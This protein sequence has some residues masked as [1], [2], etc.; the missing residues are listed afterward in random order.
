MSIDPEAPD[1]SLARR[2]YRQMLRLRRFEAE[3]G[4]AAGWRGLESVPAG[5]IEALAPGD[6]VVES[7]PGAVA[8]LRG[9]DPAAWLASG[10]AQPSRPGPAAPDAE[11]TGSA[12]LD[13]ALARRVLAAGSVVVQFL[14]AGAGMP[15][16][17]GVV[18]QGPAPRQRGAGVSTVLPVDALDAVAV[19]QAARQALAL[20]R[21]GEG[22]VLLA[23]AT[24]DSAG[25]PAPGPAA[26]RDP[27]SDPIDRLLAWARDHLL[28]S[29]CDVVAIERSV[30][31]ELAAARQAAGALVAVEPETPRPAETR[32]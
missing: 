26:P 28:L 21:A 19:W 1:R 16:G 5:V 14:P 23:C 24:R 2:L 13:S 25:P 7:G 3:A 32:S 10:L 12:A 27:C 9:A 8:L 31:D 11:A 15:R 22:P 6:G 17:R 30:D 4:L 29:H 20:A 18:L